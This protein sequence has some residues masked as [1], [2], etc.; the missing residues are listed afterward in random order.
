MYDFPC[1]N[2][3]VHKTEYRIDGIKKREYGYDMV[4]S[5]MFERVHVCVSGYTFVCV[6]MDHIQR[7]IENE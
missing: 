1:V 2:Q 3:L 4:Y 6:F 5:S 7:E